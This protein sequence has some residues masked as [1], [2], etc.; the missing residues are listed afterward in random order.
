MR[1][2]H[3]TARRT[4]SSVSR[5]QAAG[6]R[7]NRANC[8]TEK[9]KA[10]C[11]AAQFERDGEPEAAEH[12]RAQAQIHADRAADILGTLRRFNAEFT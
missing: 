3:A 10:E 4:R 7:A 9:H 8:L 1:A 5:D 12:Y 11:I 6:W 2:Q